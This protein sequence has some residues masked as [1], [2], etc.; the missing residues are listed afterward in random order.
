MSYRE[1]SPYHERRLEQ[2]TLDALLR[3]EETLEKLR[4]DFLR[5]RR[6]Q[7]VEE[8]K[9]AVEREDVFDPD[10]H[11]VGSVAKSKGKRK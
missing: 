10:G 9:P 7:L 2:Q 6:E 5:T 4:V 1:H 8:P 3:I 11:K